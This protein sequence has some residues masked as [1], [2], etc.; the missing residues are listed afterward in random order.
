MQI[1]LQKTESLQGKELIS[2]Q[3]QIMKKI[4]RLI[5]PINWFI[6]QKTSEKYG[7]ELEHN[8]FIIKI[9]LVICGI[10]TLIIEVVISK[11]HY[12]LTVR[13]I[14]ELKIQSYF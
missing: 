1:G 12:S 4:V 10:L 11:I 3:S 6:T 7:A 13:H 8:Y 14:K 5:I 9:V 2:L